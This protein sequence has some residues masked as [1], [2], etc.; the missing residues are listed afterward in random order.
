MASRRSIARSWKTAVGALLLIAGLHD[1]APAAE[2]PPPELVGTW[3]LTSYSQQFLDTKE[4]IKPFGEHPTGYMQYSVGGHFVIFMV[5]GDVPKPAAAV[6]TDAERAEIHRSMVGGYAG[7]Y[8]TDGDKLVFHVLTAWR[9]EWNGTDQLRT[10]E[11]NGNT[12]TLHTAPT[13]YTRTGQDFIATLSLMR[14]E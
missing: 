2:T 11:L 3:Q 4:T 1:P 9:P 13:K 12:L 7:S 8:K 14:V 10:F 6:Y 5:S